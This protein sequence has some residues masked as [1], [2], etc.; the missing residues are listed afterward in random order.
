M[1][2]IEELDFARWHQNRVLWV[3]HRHCRPCIRPIPNRI[4]YSEHCQRPVIYLSRI[5]WL[6]D[7]ANTPATIVFGWLNIAGG[8]LEI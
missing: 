2:G 8:V 4:L 6:P 3:F 1:P 5:D 7:G